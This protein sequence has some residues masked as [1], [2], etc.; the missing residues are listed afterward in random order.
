M[1]EKED[2]VIQHL[3]PVPHTIVTSGTARSIHLQDW[4]V[5]STK[6][7]ILTSQEIHQYSFRLSIP[8]PEMTF[9]KNS[10]EIKHS[11][12]WKM[13]FT[14][15]DALEGV[16]KTGKE[17]IQVSYAKEWVK[18]RD[19][20]CESIE[21]SKSYDW[22][23]TTAYRGTICYENGNDIADNEIMLIRAVKNKT[24][25]TKAEK[26]QDKNIDDVDKVVVPVFVLSDEVIPL[27]KLKRQDPI[28]FFEEVVL[29][30]DELSDNGMSLLSIKVRVMPE[31]L[32][33]LQRFFMRLDNVMFRIRDTRVYIEFST[34]KVLREYIEKEA[35]YHEVL[36]KISSQQNDFGIFLTDPAWVASVLPTCEKTLEALKIG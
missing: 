20:S 26:D 16:D 11:S 9:G 17:V 8:I 34:G 35:P 4:S 2:I 29:Y 22:T 24:L 27:D 19:K 31:R 5:V 3:L 15:Y 25:A 10:V 12:G 1:I 36:E 28:L 21:P 23:F 18:N 33:L 32:L 7:S 14:A 30:E 6:D 13:I